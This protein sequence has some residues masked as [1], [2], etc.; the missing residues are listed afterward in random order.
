MPNKIFAEMAK[1][2][3]IAVLVFPWLTYQIVL[4]NVSFSF[5]FENLLPRLLLF[6]IQFVMI[7]LMPTIAL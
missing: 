7:V 3:I 6:L 2:I 5:F 4:S 1:Y